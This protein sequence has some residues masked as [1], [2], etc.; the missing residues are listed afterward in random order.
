MEPK[1]FSVELHDVSRTH[2]MAMLQSARGKGVS[3]EV[4]ISD[5]KMQS[6]R[7]EKAVRRC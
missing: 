1:R 5:V 2:A 6:E 7:Q 4:H 3:G